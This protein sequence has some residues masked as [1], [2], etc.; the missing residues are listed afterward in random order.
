MPQ[1][2]CL[3]SGKVFKGESGRKWHMERV[4]GDRDAFQA[5]RPEIV[6]C[7]PAARG[8]VIQVA[9]RTGLSMSESLDLLVASCLDND[10]L[11]A[12]LTW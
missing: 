1:V 5:A 11:D 3:L 4:H 10:L 8:F 6:P 7:S 2:Q 12:V 9:D